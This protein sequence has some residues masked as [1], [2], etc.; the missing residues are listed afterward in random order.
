[1]KGDFTRFTFDPNKHYSSVRMQQG[2]I[3]LDADWNEQAEIQLHHNQITNHDVIGLCGAPK[4]NP[5]F[6]VG[7]NSGELTIG[8]GRYYV[9]GI[10]CE[11]E[12]DV[13]YLAQPDLIPEKVDNDGRYLAYLEV[14]Q[15]HLTA[16]EDAEIKDVALGGTD[17]ATRTKTVWQVKLRQ[18][19]SLS[20][21]PADDCPCFA[22]TRIAGL[23]VRTDPLEP[24][25]PCILQQGAGYHGLG[26]QLYRVE[27]HQQGKTGLATFKWSRDNGSVLCAV[28]KIVGNSITLQNCGQGIQDVFL[29]GQLIE[30]SDELRDLRGVPGML[31]TVQSVDGNTLVVAE[32]SKINAR[33]FPLSNK[34]KVRLW[35][36]Q[37]NNKRA[38]NDGSLKTG[39]D[40]IGLETG[41]MVRFESNGDYR[42]GDYWLI[43]ARRATGQI[44]W[45]HGENEFVPRLG[46]IRHRCSLAVLQKSGELWSVLKDCRR[47]FP[48]LTE[49]EMTG[50][51][52]SC[53][54]T[55]GKGGEYPDLAG[56]IGDLISK[57]KDEDSLKTICICLL[58]GVHNVKSLTVNKPTA[59]PQFNLHI[60][61]CGSSTL[62]VSSGQMKIIG[63][64]TISFENMLIKTIEC[65]DEALH[66]SGAIFLEGTENIAVRSCRVEGEGIP[67]LRIGPT[68]RHIVI[69]NSFLLPTDV[70]ERFALVIHEVTEDATLT[71]NWIRGK[72]SLGSTRVH[73]GTWPDLS[74]QE[75]AKAGDLMRRGLLN[76]GGPISGTLRMQGNRL[77]KVLVGDIVVEEIE[78]LLENDE[79]TKEGPGRPSRPLQKVIKSWAF[80]QILFSD[81]IIEE[82]NVAIIGFNQIIGESVSL[83]SNWLSPARGDDKMGRK[84][85]GWAMADSSFYAGNSGPEYVQICDLS[86]ISSKAGNTIEITRCRPE[87]H[88][89]AYRSRDGRA[90]PYRWQN[91]RIREKIITEKREANCDLLSAWLEGKPHFLLRGPIAG[92]KAPF[93][94]Y[95]IKSK[96]VRE[97]I[98]SESWEYDPS[99]AITPLDID[100][101]MNLVSYRSSDGDVQLWRRNSQGGK[102]II[103]YG[104]GAGY[105]IVPFKLNEE[106]HFVAYKSENGS[107]EVYHW[108]SDGKRETVRSEK[109]KESCKLA[110]FELEGKSYLL[111]YGPKGIF[112]DGPGRVFNSKVYIW[113]ADKSRSEAYSF[114]RQEDSIVMPF[115][116]AAVPYVM[117]Y[118]ESTAAFEIHRWV[119]KTGG[120]LD[121][122]ILATGTMPTSLKSNLTIPF[123]QGT[124]LYF[125]SYD[126]TTGLAVLCNGLA[127]GTPKNPIVTITPGKSFTWQKDSIVII[128]EANNQLHFVVYNPKSGS[129][130]L[131]RGKSEKEGYSLETV[132]TGT[133]QPSDALMVFDLGGKPHYLASM[134]EKRLIQLSSWKL[135]DAA[136]KLIWSSG[137]EKE[138]VL[139]RVQLSGLSLVLAYKPGDGKAELCSWDAGGVRKSIWINNWEKGY[140]RLLFF[141]IANQPVFLGYRPEDGQATLCRWDPANGTAEAVWSDEWGQDYAPMAFE[142]EGDSYLLIYRAAD[143]R[144]ALYR[145]NSDGSRE[146]VWQEEWGQGYTLMPFA[147]SEEGSSG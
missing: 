146:A 32:S 133:W 131:S 89:L 52:G 67:L 86:R 124:D 69:S 7:V 50:S 14:W 42:C 28:E 1:M 15:R 62:L 116:R 17:T 129:V 27:I 106:A 34:P 112:N 88:Y 47:V 139:Y 98:W 8:K 113:N 59:T 72:L 44:Q 36:C 16:V 55:V 4:H 132:W 103:G 29:P 61:G 122:E 127:G 81:N 46:I 37:P 41:I 5:G 75:M 51:T 21:N 115:N 76:L 30:I 96:A 101:Q 12:Q 73:I 39:S 70:S 128:F 78:K 3:Q 38:N 33:D 95:G 123:Y 110:P 22:V 63:L 91:D 77:T 94:F 13:S 136:S 90:Q 87:A 9:G 25:D 83:N 56:A 45:P 65:N 66:A 31:A 85:L 53:S 125:A 19:E 54:V 107:A 134:Q 141:E 120:K 100:S 92:G 111:M 84:L 140:S 144:A 64:S 57:Q 80:R 143:G 138:Y 11:N 126:R 142:L 130:L 121:L 97:K 49:I 117:I 118:K 6:A 119:L 82:E 109:W 74:R 35:D 102:D 2:R 99:Y 71:Q 20:S 18:L 60:R 48:P 79:F 104:W 24:E 105:E 135:E 43:P 147:L 68:A 40:W 23:A 10:L 137:W 108:T 114:N 93:S 58:P 145:W 26:N